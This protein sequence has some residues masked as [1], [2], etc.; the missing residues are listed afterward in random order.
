MMNNSFITNGSS[1]NEDKAIESLLNAFVDSIDKKSKEQYR[2]VRN[3]LEKKIVF[4][5]YAEK[6]FLT[7]LVKLIASDRIDDCKKLNDLVRHS[8]YAYKWPKSQKS[9]STYCNK[10][11]DYLDKLLNSTSK[12]STGI[13]SDITSKCTTP[14]LTGTEEECLKDADVY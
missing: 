9:Y 13:K 3:V 8:V 14:T 12:N 1:P 4:N 10:F 11:I 7:L 5:T 6:N 2:Q